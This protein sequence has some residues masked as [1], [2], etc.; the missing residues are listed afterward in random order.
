MEHS[1]QGSFS[2]SSTAVLSWWRFCPWGH[3]A[4]SGTLSCHNWKGDA[5]SIEQREAGNAA[6][7]STIK[8][9]PPK[10]TTIEPKM[11]AGISLK[12]SA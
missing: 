6:Q 3:L 7:H 4:M 1:L 12:I 9:Q 2:Q 5:T 10:Q 8:G 11:S